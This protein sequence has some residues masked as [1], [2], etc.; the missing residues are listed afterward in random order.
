MKGKSKNLN[1]LS[2]LRKF[3]KTTRSSSLVRE[4]HKK[5]NENASSSSYITESLDHS[6]STLGHVQTLNNKNMGL[7]LKILMK[8]LVSVKCMCWN[9]ICPKAIYIQLQRLVNHTTNS[10]T[11]S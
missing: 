6:P 1:I 11:L 2:P 9:K 5:S 8:S 3:I 7:F 4:N 10:F